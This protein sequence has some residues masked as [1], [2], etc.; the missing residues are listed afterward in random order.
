MEKINSIEKFSIDGRVVNTILI[1]SIILLLSPY[2]GGADFGVFKIPVFPEDSKK[3]LFFAGPTLLLLSIMFYVPIWNSNNKEVKNS[4]KEEKKVKKIESTSKHVVQSTPDI[5]LHELDKK[6]INTGGLS[7]STGFNIN[8]LKKRLSVLNPTL[9]KAEIEKAGNEARSIAFTEKYADPK[10][11]EK[12]ADEKDLKS[13]GLNRWDLYLEEFIK[14][15]GINDLTKLTVLDVGIGNAYASYRILSQCSELIGID[16]S[17]KALEYA[18]TKLPNATLS[19]GNAE[20]LEQIESFTIDV[21][22]SLRTYQSTLFDIKQAVHEAF[23][24]LARGGRVIISLPTIYFVKNDSGKINSYAKGLIPPKSSEPDMEFAMGIAKRIA[25]YLEML[26]F[27]NVIIDETSPF[28][29]Y[30]GGERK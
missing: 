1:I 20:N 27:K 18:K 29:I 30:I 23:R 16:V 28:E 17:K 13:L 12:L 14:K 5:V 26:G 25:W 3:I 9:S 7:I 11:D 2:F 21:Y 22:I 4:I 15:I 8:D 19:V 24:V 6:N 10:E